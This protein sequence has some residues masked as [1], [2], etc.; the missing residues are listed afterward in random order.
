MTVEEIRDKLAQNDVQYTKLYNA[1]Q[2]MVASVD[3][4]LQNAKYTTYLN[5]PDSTLKEVLD[6]RRG[7]LIVLRMGHVNLAAQDVADQID[8]ECGFAD[9]IFR[10]QADELIAADY[11]MYTVG[12]Y[13]SSKALEFIGIALPIPGG[14]AYKFKKTAIE[15]GHEED[16]RKRQAMLNNA[17]MEVLMLFKQSAAQTEEQTWLDK[18][19][20]YSFKLAKVQTEE[21]KPVEPKAP[22]PEVNKSQEVEEAEESEKASKADWREKDVLERYIVSAIKSLL[23]RRGYKKNL[24]QAYIRKSQIFEAILDKATG[25]MYLELINLQREVTTQTIKA[26]AGSPQFLNRVAIYAEE[27]C[28]YLDAKLGKR[29]K[30]RREGN[31][32]ANQSSNGSGV[33]SWYSRG[34]PR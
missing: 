33:S 28:R 1:F 8:R 34:V 23:L 2:E 27:V 24:V 22:T 9:A 29:N 13:Y 19:C 17:R 5:R 25:T 32:A 3:E 15:W 26:F 6:H 12:D 7:D 18:P 16:P 30:Q 31:Y 20:T 10:K 14:T 4:V 11:F 21:V